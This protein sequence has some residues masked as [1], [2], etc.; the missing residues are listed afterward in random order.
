MRKPLEKKIK[1]SIF[2]LIFIRITSIVQL[3]FKLRNFL[4]TFS[5]S[6]CHDMEFYIRFILNTSASSKAL[7]YSGIIKNQ[8]D[9]VYHHL[10]FER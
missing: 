7:R 5:G 2:Y 1:I 10:N 4:V 9:Q 6:V 3:F 8:L